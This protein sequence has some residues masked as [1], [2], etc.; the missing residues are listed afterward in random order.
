MMVAQMIQIVRSVLLRHRPSMR[1][2]R[3]TTMN[4]SPVVQE[5]KT[6]LVALLALGRDAAR[7]LGVSPDD[8]LAEACRA[9]DVSRSYLYALADK[10]VAALETIA[11][12]APGRP[13]R[14]A[15]VPTET[16]DAMRL[17]NRVLH[18]RL[19]HPGCVGDRGK[20]HATY[21]PGFR[22]FVLELAE[23]RS[24][25]ASVE[26]FANAVE[27]PLDTLR[28][29]LDADR[30]GM[31]P[32]VAP[33]RAPVLVPRDAARLTVEIARA[34]AAWEGSTRDFVRTAR[35]RFSLS[36]GQVF[37]V[38][39][40][41]KLISPRGGKRSA[42]RYRGSTEVVAPGA[43]LVTDGK[44]VDVQLTANDERVTVTWHAMVDQATGCRIGNVIAPTENAAA[45]TSA[46]HAAVRFLGD[47]PP[48]GVLHD[49]KPCYQ[50][51]ALAAAVAPAQLVPATPA[52]PE[53]KAILE[54]TFGLF[55]QQVGTIHLDDTNRDTLIESAVSEAVRAWSAASNHAPRPNLDGKSPAQ[56][57]GESRPSL[58]QQERDRKFIEKLRASH[59]HPQRARTYR[60]SRKLL[61]EAFRRWD[62]LAKDPH[63][64]LR[65]YL[66]SFSPPAVRRALA[67]FAAK[68]RRRAI[69][70]KFAHRY[71]VKLVQN[72]QDAVDLDVASDELLA[73]CREQGQNW[74]VAEQEDLEAMRADAAAPE[75]LVQRMT[76]RAAHAGIPVES[77]F[78]DAALIAE[79]RR[80]PALIA[81][82]RRLLPR[83]DGADYDRRL[84]LLDKLAELQE[85]LV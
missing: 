38:L 74:T 13:P 11:G 45:A 31:T 29:W 56:V 6:L 15:P 50:E 71:L 19:D 8:A 67:I 60:A 32:P 81:A 75:E 25:H 42:E 73:L 70:E 59:L 7:I 26:S 16:D 9:H 36:A 72:S 20:G 78:W 55:E 34:F 79:L 66:S 49:G 53:N 85:G 65:H 30:K 82:V 47:K 39:R 46:Y 68:Q 52:R 84:A 77:A 61:D 64:K 18:Y 28:D 48:L 35:L 62:L 51:P 41:L 76:E 37:R 12:A 33:A 5:D 22:R 1:I 4:L 24:P 40:I 83:L 58:E 3:A 69:R 21:A 10:I 14:G 43:M 27:V 63:G 57:L 17:Q 23:R 80:T 54:G 44:T 2:K